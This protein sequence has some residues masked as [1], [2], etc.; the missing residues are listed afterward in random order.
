[1]NVA[2][3]QLEQSRFAQVEPIADV[4]ARLFYDKLIEIDPPAK[5]LFTSDI[6]E[7]GKKLMKLLGIAVR[8]LSNLDALLPA[9]QALGMRHVGYGVLDA[10]SATVGAAPFVDAGTGSR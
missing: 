4:A 2:Q 7:Q 9:V 8:G 3:I 6:T 1:M 10:H 5:P